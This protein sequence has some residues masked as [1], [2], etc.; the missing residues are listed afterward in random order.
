MKKGGGDM[1][2]KAKI[3]LAVG[4]LV[5]PLTA[6]ATLLGPTPYLS[7][8]DSPFLPSTGFT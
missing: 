8:A 3:L 4:L 1:N 6:N 2:R 5:G 7:S